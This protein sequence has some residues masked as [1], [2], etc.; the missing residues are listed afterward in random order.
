MLKEIGEDARLRQHILSI[1]IPILLPDGK[2][3]L[4]EPHMKSPQAEHG[5]V[6]LTP[7]NVKRWQERLHIL[8]TAIR[9]A[10]EADTSSYLDRAYPS[11][12]SWQDTDVIEVG[13]IAGWLFIH[14]EKGRREKM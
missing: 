1:G 9:G 8:Q 3:F 11:L 14:E 13:E 6:D 7:A 12:I 4:R 10:L 5:W 2:H